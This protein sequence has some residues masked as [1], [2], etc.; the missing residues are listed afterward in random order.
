M[1][2]SSILLALE[3]CYESQSSFVSIAANTVPILS[4]SYSIVFKVFKAV[5]ESCQG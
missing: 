2:L 1:E 4:M 3:K 5:L